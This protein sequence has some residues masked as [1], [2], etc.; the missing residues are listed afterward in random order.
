MFSF[1]EIPSKFIIA[2]FN[3][4]LSVLFYDVRF[5]NRR[6]RSDTECMLI[7]R[8]IKLRIIQ[9][10]E[11]A[12]FQNSVKRFLSNRYENL[13]H[14]SFTQFSCLNKTFPF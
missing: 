3:L 1:V 5:Q 7:I 12:R 10:L 2:I 8:V 13:H 11:R 14:E 6:A 9:Q 4:L